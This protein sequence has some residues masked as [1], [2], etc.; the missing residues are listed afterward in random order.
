[1]NQQETEIL[2]QAYAVI[3][4]LWCSPQDVDMVAVRNEAQNISC[5]VPSAGENA[6]KAFTGNNNLGGAAYSLFEF[7]QSEPIAEE[8]YIELFEL[9]PDCS[10]YLGSHS[11]E[12]PKTCAGGAVSDR[13]EYMIDILGI[14]HHFGQSLDG[15]E[16]A[17]YLPVM[18][19]FLSLTIDRQRDPVREKFI[20]EYFLPFLPPVRKRLEELNSEY[21]R[22]MDAVERLAK[23]DLQFSIPGNTEPLHRTEEEKQT[24][25]INPKISNTYVG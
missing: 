10:L 13:N 9:N 8:D 1:M 25:H 16:L 6:E 5:P 17:D 20:K 22:L 19:D 14:Y 24:K 12:E 2:K 18:I 15:R 7:L 23:Y 3:A 11:Y 21:W 4:Q